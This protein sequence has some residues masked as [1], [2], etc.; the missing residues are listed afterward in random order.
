MRLL[1]LYAFVGTCLL[2]SLAFPGRSQAA[3]QALL[4]SVNEYKESGV[5]QLLGPP[6]DVVL[7]RSILT[8]RFSV[9]TAN[10]KVLS[11]PTHSQIERAFSDLV[12]RVQPNDQVYIH[13]SGHGSWAVAPPPKPGEAA[14]RRGQDQ[15]WVAFGARSKKR[16]G[17]DSFDVLD[18]EIALWLDPLY[19][20][21]PDVVFVSDSCHSATVTRGEQRGARSA[22]GTLEPHPLRA[23][24]ARVPPPITGLRIGAA[25][26]FESAVEFA[27]KV[28]GRCLGKDGCYGAFTWNWAAALTSSRPDESW[29][30]VFRRTSA[31]LIA[32][33]GVLQRPQMEG[34]SDRAIFQGQFTS[35]S[36][37]VPVTEVKSNGTVVLG[38]GLL[39]GVVIGSIFEA[40][41]GQSRASRLQ[42][43]DS[44]ASS[45]EAKLTTGTVKA[46]DVV[47]ELE[48][49][50]KPIRLFIGSAFNS[51]ADTPAVNQLR[52]SVSDAQ[53]LA[54]QGFAIVPTR[55]QADWRIEFVRPSTAL[56][57]DTV[58]L[59]KVA[60]GAAA[61]CGPLELWVVSPNEQLMDA[62][63]RIPMADPATASSRLLANLEAFA[64][65]REVRA[66]GAQG[67]NTPLQAQVSV[68][69]PPAGDAKTCPDGA[70]DGSGWQKFPAVAIK[71][72]DKAQIRL[73][74]CLAFTLVNSASNRTW[75]GYLLSV[76]PAYAV[77]PIWPETGAIEDDARIEPHTTFAVTDSFY[78]LS[79]RGRETFLFVAS[80]D[81]APVANVARTGMRGKGSA[82][83]GG[84]LS[85]LIHASALTRGPETAISEW[86]AESLDLDVGASNE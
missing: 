17:K 61:A 31:A 13:Y 26:D 40:A 9:P 76:D 44:K 65:A 3:V 24:I 2:G 82:G 1:S 30:D 10:V 11:N 15:T 4:I 42:I 35:P 25:R 84:A 58:A 38:A 36:A 55:D 45:A 49:R 78:R 66:I 72:L 37:L 74:D 79:D 22:D 59:P 52:K 23:T 29:G 18:K 54:L 27:P 50:S 7:I 16:A 19:K 57:P 51:S 81:P 41:D 32:T 73:G 53:Q 70:K 20:I 14:E 34:I 5:T 47:R 63:M 56:P 60:C 83:P 12:A 6:N 67:N 46:G 80:K 75:Y 43:T 85:R 48:H 71:A 28:G 86:G 39:S 33:P 64:H 21:T 68:I 62:K 69:R 77:R 8:E